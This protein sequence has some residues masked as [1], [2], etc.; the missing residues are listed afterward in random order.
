MRLSQ[1]ENDGAM[2]EAMK[3]GRDAALEDGEQG[4]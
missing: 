2:A 1:R 4:F 3:S